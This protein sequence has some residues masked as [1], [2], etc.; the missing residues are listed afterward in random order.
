MAEGDFV[1]DPDVFGG[2]GV[3]DAGAAG[4]KLGGG[5]G[6]GGAYAWTRWRATMEAVGVRVDGEGREGGRTEEGARAVFSCEAGFYFMGVAG[7]G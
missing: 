2:W 1:A 3:A 7:V 6:I 5:G 4:G